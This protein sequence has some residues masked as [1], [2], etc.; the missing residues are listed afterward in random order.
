MW[1]RQPDLRLSPLPTARVAANTL[2]ELKW[3]LGMDSHHHSPVN[4]RSCSFITT[5]DLNWSRT[6][7]CPGF[8]VDPN[9][10]DWLS[11]SC[12]F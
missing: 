12:A 9:D 1:I 2:A 10:A 5:E 6:R 7:C 11:S 3:L 4:S 8:P